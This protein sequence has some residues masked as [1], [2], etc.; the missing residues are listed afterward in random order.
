M[1]LAS[2]KI[3]KQK[4]RNRSARLRAKLRRKNRTRFARLV[5]G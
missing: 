2:R 5:A 1:F 4:P 3:T